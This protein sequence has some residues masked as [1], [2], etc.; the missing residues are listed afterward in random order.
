MWIL[1]LTL[2]ASQGV[3]VTSIPGFSTQSE[4]LAAAKAWRQEMGNSN[5]AHAICVHRQ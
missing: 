2:W 3:S 1:I 4:C 5:G